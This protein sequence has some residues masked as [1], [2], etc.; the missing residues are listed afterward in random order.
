MENN[1]TITLTEKEVKYI[2]LAATALKHDASREAREATDDDLRE[3]K[4]RTAEMWKEIHDK[5]KDQRREQEK[6]E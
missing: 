5:I 4:E 1:I 3:N 6:A 2:L